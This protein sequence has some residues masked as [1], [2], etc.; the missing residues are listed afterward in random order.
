MNISPNMSGW[1]LKLFIK[2][3]HFHSRHEKPIVE[4]KNNN[5]LMILKIMNINLLPMTIGKKEQN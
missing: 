3:T 2:E 1:N 4:E 5:K